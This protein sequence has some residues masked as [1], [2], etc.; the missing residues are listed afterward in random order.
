MDKARPTS[1]G[2]VENHFLCAHMYLSERNHLIN[3]GADPQQDCKMKFQTDL[4]FLGYA[5]DIYNDLQNT[6]GK[7]LYTA[8]TNIV[9]Y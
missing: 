6:L 2:K 5:Y 9:Q 8:C 7:M 1:Q 3:S 4:D